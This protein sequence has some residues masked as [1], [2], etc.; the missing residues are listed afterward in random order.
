[1]GNDKPKL[2]EEQFDEI[3]K[4][5]QTSNMTFKDAFIA[6]GYMEKPET[7]LER[8]ER[9]YNEWERQNESATILTMDVI[10]AYRTAI[11]E[12][13]DTINKIYAE[14]RHEA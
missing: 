7:A 9:L 14:E 1:M 8:A 4:L 6:C 10:N 2:T 11:K 13:T 5:Y 12:L 3:L